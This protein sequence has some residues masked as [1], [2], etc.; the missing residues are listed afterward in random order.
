MILVC[1]LDKQIILRQ[2]HSQERFWF[3]EFRVNQN[4]NI[5]LGKITFFV[6]HMVC[7]YV[8]K[9]L[10]LSQNF[11]RLL[12]IANLLVVKLELQLYILSFIV[13]Q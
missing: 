11:K 12:E 9:V 7:T 4:F 8:I 6:I 3:Y 5:P 13:V 1:G 2:S 10:D